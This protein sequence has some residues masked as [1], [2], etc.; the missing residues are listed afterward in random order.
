MTRHPDIGPIEDRALRA[1]TDS[2]A[3]N[4]GAVRI[5]LLQAQWAPPPVL[6]L[7]GSTPV[8]NGATLGSLPVLRRRCGQVSYL[9][10]RMVSA[11]RPAPRSEIARQAMPPW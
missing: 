3:L 1:E 9:C 5:E 4:G 6:P 11:S 2:D 7:T 8:G 10:G